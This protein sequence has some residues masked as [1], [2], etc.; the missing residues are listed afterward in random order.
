VPWTE[1]W[2]PT[3]TGPLSHFSRRLE[4]CGSDQQRRTT[5]TSVLISYTKEW[6]EGKDWSTAFHFSVFDFNFPSLIFDIKAEVLL[7]FL[8]CVMNVKYMEH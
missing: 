5:K 6:R 4:P 3:L 7:R 8:T 1:S 2:R